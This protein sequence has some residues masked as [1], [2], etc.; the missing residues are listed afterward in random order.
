MEL[1]LTSLPFTNHGPAGPAYENQFKHYQSYLIIIAL[2]F[3]ALSQLYFLHR[4]LKL[5]STSVLYPFVFCVYNVVAILDGLIYFDQTDRLPPLHAGLVGLGTVILLGGVLALSW[6]LDEQGLQQ[7]REWNLDHPVTPTA[8]ISALAPGMGLVEDTLTES[9]SATDDAKSDDEESG[10]ISRRLPGASESTPLL[11]RQ[12]S[13]KVVNFDV[14]A[15]T[16]R[17]PGTGYGTT[18]GSRSRSRRDSASSYSKSRRSS[19]LTTPTPKRT[20]FVLPKWDR[21]EVYGALM[22]DKEALVS[23]VAGKGDRRHRRRQT[24]TGMPSKRAIQSSEGTGIESDGD[25][26]GPSGP[27]S[28]NGIQSLKRSKTAPFRSSEDATAWKKRRRRPGEGGE[29]R[30]VSSPLLGQNRPGPARRT[31]S[32]MVEWVGGLVVSNR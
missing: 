19:I 10:L 29:G 23:P 9:P 13:H 8:Q 17:R 12:T 20:R 4:G 27:R 30:S 26:E 5:A 25:D 6:R 16:E 24:V 14:S 15:D 7:E 32:G 2:V 11:T 22:D 3:F 31:T 18:S 1:I 28:R 21:A